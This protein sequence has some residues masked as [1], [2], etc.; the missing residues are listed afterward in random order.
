[1]SS[2]EGKFI[3]KNRFIEASKIIII[4]IM[5]MSLLLTFTDMFILG[6]KWGD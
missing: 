1:M 5:I 3:S 4:I 6:C 2:N